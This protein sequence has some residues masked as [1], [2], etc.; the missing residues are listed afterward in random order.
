[1]VSGS[2]TEA[3]QQARERATDLNQQ[4]LAKAAAEAKSEQSQSRG[5]VSNKPNRL[6]N[7]LATTVTDVAKTLD[8]SKKKEYAKSMHFLKIAVNCPLS[9]PLQSQAVLQFLEQVVGLKP[10]DPRIQMPIKMLEGWET[11]SD[12][13][14][15]ELLGNSLIMKV[16]KRDLAIKDFPKFVETCKGLFQ[17]SAANEGGHV[18]TYIPQLAS[19]NPDFWGVSMCSVDGQCM[20][21]G[22]YDVPFCVQSASKPITYCV[23]LE[24]NGD[25][26][27]HQHVGREPSGRN[28]NDRSLMQR[29]GGK[30]NSIP[31]NPCIN[32]GAI[33]TSSLVKMD[34]AE[35][36][37]FTYMINVWEKL[38]GGARVSFQNDTF[39][40]ERST[41][42]RN[43]CLAYMMMEEQAFPE[44]TDLKKTLEAYFTWCSIEI[45]AQSMACVAA[46]LAN[47]GI[48]PLTNER[49]F[50]NDTV[51]SCLSLMM[52]CGMYDFSGQFAFEI[53]FPSKSGVSGV[54][55]V[56]IP[57]VCGFAT[58]SPRL[59][60]LGNSVR[61]ID[62][63]QRLAKRYPFH[64]FSLEYDWEN[65]CPGMVAPPT[66]HRK[67]RR[68]GANMIKSSTTFFSGGEEDTSA[69]QKKANSLA[70]DDEDE[71]AT[72]AS[73][74]WSAY[75]G[76]ERR[77]RQLA[78]RGKNISVPDYDH[79]TAIQLAACGGH[80]KL[81]TLMIGLQADI[82]AW[83]LHGCTAL[84]DAARERKCAVKM[85][86]ENAAREQGQNKL[87]RSS[88]K[89]K[90]EP[91]LF[92]YFVGLS[93]I[94]M[95]GVHRVH[96]P[97]LISVLNNCGF[98]LDFDPRFKFLEDF[99]EAFS[100]HDLT[101]VVKEH[102]IISRALQGRLVV[103][104]FPLLCEK[105]EALFARMIASIQDNDPSNMCQ[106]ESLNAMTVDGQRL[107]IGGCE[108]YVCAGDLISIAI[109]A[110]ST[111]LLGKEMVMQHVAAEPS[112]SDSC[113]T[114]LNSD[115]LPYNAFMWN[116][117]L[118]LLALLEEKCGNAVGLIEAAWVKLCQDTGVECDESWMKQDRQNN[119]YRVSVLLYTLLDINKF[120]DK[121]DSN[122]VMDMFFY[123]RALKVSTQNLGG[124]AAALANR[125]HHPLT[126]TKI[127]Q[128]ETV[129]GILS[130]MYSAGCYAQSGE[131]SFRIGI[132]TKSSSEGIMLLVFPSLMGMCVVSP[133]VNQNGVS[134]GAVKYCEMF[135][136]E[137]NCHMLAGTASA[138]QKKDPSL[139]H[140]TVDIDLCNQ[141]LSAAQNGEL[142]TLL[143]VH[144]LGFSL[145]CADYDYRSAAHIAACNNQVEVLEYLVKIGA[146]MQAKDRWNLTPYDDAKRCGH[147]KVVSLLDVQEAIAKADKL[148]G[149]QCKQ[150]ITP[151]T[152]NT[153][154]TATTAP[155]SRPHS[156]SRS[157]SHCSSK[158]SSES[159]HIVG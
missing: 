108:Q 120:P 153:A 34:C 148:N 38:S 103:P 15:Q 36:D 125:G 95:D 11:I 116:G 154:T 72:N 97:T 30:K 155:T 101:E 118:T 91:S 53:G 63:C 144:E 9:E 152:F 80:D 157:H 123:L 77:I 128:V 89:T 143:K 129:K 66:S 132:P 94:D 92:N 32:A 2:S 76:D 67:A 158:N 142:M 7:S 139:Y 69:R 10:N 106:D 31:H 50:T 51:Q 28:F 99:P 8:S 100:S 83:D 107:Q 74:W 71:D 47:G 49:I 130:M 52:S 39:M 105:V 98:Y 41:A 117:M 65:W 140:M 85:L 88:L 20:N 149:L 86:L 96:K 54:L 59:D 137:F 124:L 16:M 73:L 12:E 84:D 48:C 93:V 37:R 57:R 104:N 127:F 159:S 4:A 25:E 110:V 62:F 131:I 29:E 138:A 126:R 156:R 13:Q 61:G 33:M 78:A 70:E 18:A 81:I 102:P 58:F 136:S 151:S 90:L 35:W 82:N 111:E 14:A 26:K 121:V 146:N 109:L 122:Q 21:I 55:C 24:I 27:V 147:Q 56:V 5:K 115:G 145:D 64:V 113:A 17:E 75:W 6:W 134:V 45:T 79:R 150:A 135:A 1:M 19:Q 141:A 44:G 119:H 42:S 112:G 40:G 3:Y 133:Q 68:S 114:I 60:K 23:A 22:D 46:S 87:H 43:F